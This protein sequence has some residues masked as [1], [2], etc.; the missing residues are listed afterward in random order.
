MKYRYL[1]SK[2]LALGLA[3]I[4]ATV[5]QDAMAAPPAPFNWSTVV[6]NGD[7]MPTDAC[8]TDLTKCRTFN[9]Y[10]QPSVSLNQ[11]VVIRA[12]S[13]GGQGLGQPVHGVYTRDMASGGP[14]VKILDRD[15]LV[16][17]PNNRDTLFIEPPSF[18]RID[19]GSDTIATRGNHQPVWK[20]I[21]PVTNEI[22]EQ[23]GTT[24]IYTNPFSNL[25]TG[26]SKLGSVPDFSFFE[27]PEHPSTFSQ[28][29]LR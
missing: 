18:P 5:V 11:V 10:N 7:F 13:R 23:V 14:V 3:V 22:I 19:I 17:Q 26:A 16:P 28:G 1:Q 12:R 25:I 6:N 9:S 21:D 29:L 8:A 15:T 4:A 24:G 27:V 20:V 2:I